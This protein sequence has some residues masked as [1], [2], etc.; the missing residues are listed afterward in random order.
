MSIWKRAYTRY[1][2]E[3]IDKIMRSVIKTR[4]AYRKRQGGAQGLRFLLKLCLTHYN[5]FF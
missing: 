5:F 1:I 4:A 2:D 3:W